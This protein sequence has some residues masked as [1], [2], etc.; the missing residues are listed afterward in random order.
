MICSK[1]SNTNL[2]YLHVCLSTFLSLVL[3]QCCHRVA[4][5]H[6]KQGMLG[7]FVQAISGL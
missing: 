2:F 6:L 1:K 5:L 4:S 7:C 3:S